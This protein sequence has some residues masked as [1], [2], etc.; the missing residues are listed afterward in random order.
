MELFTFFPSLF[1]VSFARRPLGFQVCIC[2]EFVILIEVYESEKAHTYLGEVYF[3]NL[4][5]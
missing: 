2:I 4:F 3:N 1:L 5:R